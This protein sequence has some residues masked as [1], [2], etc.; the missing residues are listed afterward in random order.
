MTVEAWAAPHP[1]TRAYYCTS[2]SRRS[3]PQSKSRRGVCPSGH[4]LVLTYIYRKKISLAPPP[5]PPYRSVRGGSSMPAWCFRVLFTLC[6]TLHVLMAATGHARP[7]I[8]SGLRRRCQQI[9]RNRSCRHQA[10]VSQV[11]LPALLHLTNTSTQTCLLSTWKLHK[12]RSLKNISQPGW[13]SYHLIILIMDE[14]KYER[15]PAL[16]V[17][18]PFSQHLS[19]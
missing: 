6:V 14:Q 17:M 11:F 13:W 8:H 2:S 3:L 4:E 19:I 7:L 15:Q 1:H 5:A 18:S 12:R 16:P 9:C 10:L